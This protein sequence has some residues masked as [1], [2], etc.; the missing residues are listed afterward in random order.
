MKDKRETKISVS[1]KPQ[2]NIP[3]HTNCFYYAMSSKHETINIQDKNN[4]N[5]E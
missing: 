4:T 1:R 2:Y 5:N 3:K